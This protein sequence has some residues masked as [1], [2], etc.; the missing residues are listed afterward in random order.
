MFFP[1]T[2]KEIL[3]SGTIYIFVVV[4]FPQLVI[5][6]GLRNGYENPLSFGPCIVC[7]ASV[8][9]DCSGPARD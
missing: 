4:Y 8:T 9:A 1:I 3:T 5:D 2:A 6:I 7:T